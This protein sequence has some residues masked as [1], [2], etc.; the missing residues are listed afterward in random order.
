MKRELIQNIKAIPLEADEAIDRTGFLSA[1]VAIKPKGSGDLTIK[2]THA[3]T[4]AGDYAAVED[5]MLVVG[6]EATFKSVASGDLV[7]FDLDLVGC[8]PFIK[9]DFEGDGEG[10][11]APAV[12]V[13]GD[14][15]LAPVEDTPSGE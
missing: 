4:K 15:T 6:G 12:I 3:D 2:V 7:K 14:P 1:V 9:V 8:K 13:L 10:S 11:S 5:P